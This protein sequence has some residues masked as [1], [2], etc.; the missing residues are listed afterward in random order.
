MIWSMFSRLDTHHFMCL[1]RLCTEQEG[2][3]YYYTGYGWSRSFTSLISML[4]D[5]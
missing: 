2:L 1:D 4:E 5:F 3:W